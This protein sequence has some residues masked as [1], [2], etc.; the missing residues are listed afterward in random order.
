MWRFFNIDELRS[1]KPHTLIFTHSFAYKISANIRIRIFYDNT[2]YTC[3]SSNNGQHISTDCHPPHEQS[4]N[5]IGEYLFNIINKRVRIDSGT[6]VLIGLQWNC[7][8]TGQNRCLR[9]WCLEGHPRIHQTWLPQII[10]ISL[11]WKRILVN[12]LSKLIDSP[13][14]NVFSWKDQKRCSTAVKGVLN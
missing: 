3:T 14:R 10:I 12:F 8:L 4:E 2:F 6:T 9:I 1:L 7:L 5:V 11:N 13:E